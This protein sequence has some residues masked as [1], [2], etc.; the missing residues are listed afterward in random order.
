MGPLDPAPHTPVLGGAVLAWLA[1]RGDGVYVDCT[2]G[3]GGHAAF[4]AQRLTTGRLI[5]LDRDASAVAMARAR[6]AD[7]PRATVRHANYATLRDTLAQED[8]ARVD[9]LLV[10]AGVSSMQLDDPERGFSF[11]EDGPLDMRMDRSAGPTAAA[12]LAQVSEADLA[13]TLKRYGD[14]RPA[15]RIAA[16]VVQRRRAGQLTRTGDL[17]AAVREALPFVKGEPEEI[18]TVFQAVRMAVNEE[19]RWLENVLD[20]AVDLLVAGGRLVVIAFHSGEDR[21]VKQALRAASRP[22]RLLHADGRVRACRPPRLRL[23]TPRPVT[24]DPEELRANP[25]A[26]S[27]KLR[28]A[29]RLAGEDDHETA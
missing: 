14:V 16:A 18:R 4:I 22:E 8:V 1:V 3:A 27:A 10:D 12:Y 24:P 15:R 21:V 7:C 17:A 2:A 23:L 6:L 9:G 26:K 29:E 25:R 11:Q 19:L 20:Q 28:A 13:Q 5:A